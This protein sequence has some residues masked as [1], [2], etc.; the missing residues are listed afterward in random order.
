MV[1]LFLFCVCLSFPLGCSKSF[2]DQNKH[3]ESLS[4]CIENEYIENNNNSAKIVSI[5]NI[6]H[7]VIKSSG[8]EQTINLRA[9]NNMKWWAVWDDNNRFWIYSA[10]IGMMYIL[11][12]QEHWVINYPT[13][14]EQSL[15]PK[16][17]LEKR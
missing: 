7:A 2:G 1:R 10:D 5:D 11:Q 16:S 8:K 15:I 14:E 3:Q 17:L 6:L 13:K 9:S 4:C 12:E